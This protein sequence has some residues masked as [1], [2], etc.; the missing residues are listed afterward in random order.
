MLELEVCE[1]T[2]SR[3]PQEGV[4]SY[5][6]LRR[7]VLYHPKQD[8][9]NIVMSLRPCSLVRTKP[10]MLKKSIPVLVAIDD[11]RSELGTMPSGITTEMEIRIK[12]KL[13]RDRPSNPCL[14]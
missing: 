3:T 12:I 14:C 6:K 7:Q 10:E 1:A 13:C 5:L 2:P 8:Q 9:S 4:T 11:S